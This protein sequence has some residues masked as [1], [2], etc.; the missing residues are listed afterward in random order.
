MEVKASVDNRVLSLYLPHKRLV[1]VNKID[2]YQNLSKY[3]FNQ[4]EKDFLCECI[5]SQDQSVIG[6]I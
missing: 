5:Y 6:I 3:K 4:E 1:K 2:V